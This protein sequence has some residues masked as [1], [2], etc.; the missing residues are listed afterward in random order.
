MKPEAEAERSEDYAEGVAANETN[1]LIG[2]SNFCY[3]FY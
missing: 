3:I 2:V 1:R